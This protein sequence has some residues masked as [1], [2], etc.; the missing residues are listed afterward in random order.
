MSQGT[1]F[2]K[3]QYAGQTTDLATEGGSYNELPRVQNFSAN[4]NNN[5]IYDRGLGEGIN[6]VNSYFGPYDVSGSVGFS[7]VDFDVLKHWVGPKSGSGSSGDPYTLTE[8]TSI[9][10]DTSSLQPCSFERLNDSE[11]TD[12][13]DVYIGCTGTDF[14]LSAEMA[15]KLNCSA[16]WIGRHDIQRTTH[17][18]YT[19]VTENAFIMINGTW[20]WGSTPSAL[21]GVRSFNLNYNNGLV[22]DTRSIEGR[23]INTPK[24]GQ[25]EYKF[26]VTIIMAQSL[27]ASIYTDFYGGALTPEDGSS[28]INPTAN[29]EFKVE[30]VNGSKYANLWLDHCSID[31]ISKATSL[32]EGLVLL[33]F[34]GTARIGK[35]NA[36]ITWWTV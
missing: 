22:T 24:F 11:S 9:D 19:P 34:N 23:F 36:P 27:Q 14:S 7:V 2:T 18:T 16:N 26:D 32:G 13:V 17:A 21:S 33:T 1:I 28:S 3:V 5:I 29:L 35:D 6:A 25:R 15:G 20:K 8:A 4:S 31:S 10:F 12:N 30:L